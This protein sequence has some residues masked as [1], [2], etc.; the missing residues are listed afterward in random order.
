MNQGIRTARQ[1]AFA[2]CALLLACRQAPDPAQLSAVD[3][4]ISATDA[5]VLTLNEL[6]RRRYERSDSLYAGQRTAFSERFTDT[7]PRAAAG[8]LGQQFITLRAAASMGA[9]HE[10]VLDQLIAS[11]ERLRNLRNDISGGAL[12]AQQAALDIDGE[13]RHHASSIEAVHRVIDNYRTLQQAWDRRDSVMV[14]LA[15]TQPPIA[16]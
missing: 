4:L 8:A 6:D 5:A 13:Q 7:L 11:S 9:Q 14:L 1:M 3:Q 2:S 12:D 16:P 15:N 10:H